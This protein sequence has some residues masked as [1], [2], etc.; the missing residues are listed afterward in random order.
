MILR[1]VY[2]EAGDSFDLATDD[3][4]SRLDA[5]YATPSTEWLRVNLV[6][7]VDGSAAGADGT[8]ASLTA[9]AD[10]KVL[11]AI[12]RAADIVLVGAES[13]RR[14]GYV[15]PKTAPLAVVTGSGDLSGHALPSPLP[16]GRVFVLCPASA[17]DRAAESVPG[18]TVLI[19]PDVDGRM[20][21]TDIVHALRSGGMN[22]I[23]CEGGPSL[24]RLLLA[25]SLVNELCL[26]TSPRLGGSPHPLSDHSVELSLARLLVD[27]TGVVF[28]RWSVP[29]G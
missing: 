22:S 8:S 16:P 21:G 20:A 11:G 7:S 4:R 27:D 14:E 2:P 13:V 5:L 3:A 18:A 12:R 29:R 19:L 6:L 10:R 24:V 9:G 25:E 15:L 23:V 17:A 26:S 1:D 28:A